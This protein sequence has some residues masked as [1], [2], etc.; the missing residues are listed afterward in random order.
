MIDYV[1][2][3]IPFQDRLRLYVSTYISFPFFSFFVFPFFIFSL[4]SF[5]FF[6]FSLFSFPFFFLANL[7]FLDRRWQSR[8]VRDAFWRKAYTCM[9]WTFYDDHPITHN[10]R[11]CI[12]PF[13][14]F[15]CFVLFCFVVLLVTIT[16]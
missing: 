6:L 4:F 2:T 8:A 5:P 9:A 14:F 12:C 3:Y 10:F 1:F 7:K 16:P 11:V 15:F 13:V